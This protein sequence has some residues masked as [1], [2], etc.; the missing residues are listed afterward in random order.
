LEA[1][2]VVVKI[3]LESREAGGRG[4]LAGVAAAGV[5]I[6]SG[7]FGADSKTGCAGA[8][9]GRSRAEADSAGKDAGVA[10]LEPDEPTGA[11][12]ADVDR[13]GREAPG[14]GMGRRSVAG[15][16]NG[17]EVR[18]LAAGILLVGGRPGPGALAEPVAGTVGGMT[19]L[20]ESA[21]GVEGLPVEAVEETETDLAGVA[22]PGSKSGVVRRAI[23][24]LAGLTGPETVLGRESGASSV[25][26]AAGE[27]EESADGSG[28]EATPPDG[29]RG[30]ER[31]GSGGAETGGS[32]AVSALDGEAGGVAASASGAGFRISRLVGGRDEAA[33]VRNGG[34]WA[35][36]TGSGTVSGLAGAGSAAGGSVSGVSGEG[37]RW[38]RPVGGRVEFAGGVGAS[39]LGRADGPSVTRN[40]VVVRGLG[41]PGGTSSGMGQG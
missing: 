9:T 26:G 14:E 8:V 2:G 5:R 4:M 35:V 12:P 33:V 39:V 31:A 40:C 37:R 32:G 13:I 29:D 22:S 7:A 11:S 27:P 36:V 3:D 41:F 15:P 34:A 19:R 16:P 23:R 28:E 21:T 30:D 38:S 10:A 1:G 6:G 20:P 25:F 17:G 24:L 18:E